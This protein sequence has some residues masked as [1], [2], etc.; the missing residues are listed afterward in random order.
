MGLTAFIQAFYVKSGWSEEEGLYLRRGF[1]SAVQQ[2]WINS[3]GSQ[4]SITL[5]RFAVPAGATSAFDD[6]SSAWKDKPKPVTIL[7][8]PAI[9]A[10][11]WSDP[12]MDTLGNTEVEFAVAVGDIMIRVSEYTAVRPDADAAKALLQKQYDVLKNGS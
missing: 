3:D 4:Q 5:I 7:A 12:T 10:V 6:L 2:G 11:G 1:V 8:D 9:G